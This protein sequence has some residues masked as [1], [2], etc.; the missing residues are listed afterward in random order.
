MNQY[1]GELKG[2]NGEK[3]SELSERI[4]RL[5][6]PKI[7]P[8]NMASSYIATSDDEIFSGIMDYIRQ[9]IEWVSDRRY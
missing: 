3:V 1:I 7:K 5:L 4:G 9:K 2:D 8:P 6:H